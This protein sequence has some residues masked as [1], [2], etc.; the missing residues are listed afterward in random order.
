MLKDALPGHPRLDRGLVSAKDG[1]GIARRLQE[2]VD[3]AD[4][5]RAEQ[6][7]L[8]L[9]REPVDEYDGNAGAA[10]RQRASWTARRRVQCLVGRL[11]ELDGR[12][13]L[14]R[15]DAADERLR[16]VDQAGE[17]CLGEAGRLAVVA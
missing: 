9:D 4:L 1:T 17:L 8:L 12:G 7:G 11:G 16:A 2:T 14:A 3:Q 5:E 10:S 13:G 6:D 15:L